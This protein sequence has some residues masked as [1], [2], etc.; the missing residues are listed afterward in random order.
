MYFNMIEK[1]LT[2]HPCSSLLSLNHVMCLIGF[3]NAKNNRNGAQNT[4]S[5]V[6]SAKNVLKL[7]LVH[8]NKLFAQLLSVFQ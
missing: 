8:N 5:V 2:Q 6:R 7:L 3:F 4:R 1:K